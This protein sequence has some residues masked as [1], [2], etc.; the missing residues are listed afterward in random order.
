MNE[1]TMEFVVALTHLVNHT[2]HRM[3]EIAEAHNRDFEEVAEAAIY[4][5]VAVNEVEDRMDWESGTISW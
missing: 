2:V 5:I 1:E 3:H 4:G